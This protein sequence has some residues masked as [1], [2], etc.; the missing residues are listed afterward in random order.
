MR[1]V[2]T[3]L[4]LICSIAVHAQ[5]TVTGVVKDGST[6]SP[7]PFASII[8]QDGIIIVGDL[9]GKFT[10]E[11]QTLQQELTISYT[12]YEDKTIKLQAGK[13]FYTVKLKAKPQELNEVII[14]QTDAGAQIIRHAINRKSVND[15]QQKLNSFRY[16]TY[17]RLII[18]A[19]PDSLS[20]KIDSVFVSEKAGRVLEKI[21]STGFKF[22]K[23]IEK[24][25]LYQTE[26]VS[27]YNYTKN[28]GLKE[29]ILA[30]RMAGFKEPIY[31]FIGLQLQSYSVYNDVDLLETKYIG[32]LDDN[33]FSEYKYRVLDTVA[34]DNRETYMI[35]FTPKRA[36]KKKRLDGILYIDRATFG[37]AKAVFRVKN[38]LDINSTHYFKFEKDLNL[39]FPD[40]KTLKIVKGNNKQDINILGETIKFDA[41]DEASIPR[42]KEASDFVYVYSESVNSEKEFNIPLVIKNPAIAIEIKEEAI[43]RPEEYWKQYRTTTLD[44]RGLNTYPA[45]DS[46]VAEEKIE[47]LVKLG[48]RVITGYLP[49]GF[50]DLDLR[51]IVKYNNYEGFRLGLGGIT[52]KKFSETFRIGGYGVYGTKDGEFKYNLG[53]AVRIGKFSDSWIGGSY[54]E[55]VQEIGST[56]FATDKRVFKIYDPR[57][58]NVSTFYKYWRWQA[59]LET[60][61]IPKTESRWS[62]N[63]TAVDPRFDYVFNVND[64][65]YSSYNLST[66]EGT[67]QWNPFSD[68]MQTPEGRTEVEKRFP[69]FTFQ[70]TQAIK[71][72]LDGDFNF[73]KFDFRAEYEKKYINGQK[74][75]IVVQTGLALGEIPITHLYSTSPNNLDKD[76][77]IARITFAGKNSFETMYFNEFFSSQYGMFQ[78]KHALRRQNLFWKIKL[79]PVLVTR[80]V[81]GN[82]EHQERQ[83]GQPYKTLE[84]GY[85]E[86]G[87]E[88]N[89]IF[90]GLGL[91]FFYRYGP[92]H[93][94]DFDR[95][96]SIKLSFVLKL[97]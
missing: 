16:K 44:E 8:A 46:L 43:S 2:Y 23:L 38:V 53:A 76:G 90:Q 52:N 80:T 4:L 19:N 58:I 82:M 77:V 27:E 41:I 45:L 26:K 85:Y 91:T 74:T 42:E 36:K 66:F 56:N 5:Y 47:K 22:K 72:A 25:H 79:T 18:T 96:I 28:E 48:K 59:Y 97:F 1:V 68:F 31:E 92:Y 54:T 7:L 39:W 84:K 88:L 14:T 93:L 34:I 6:N 10:L 33:A 73:S 64:Q 17:N 89:E 9:D 95:N 15:P 51:Q 81:W 30:T 94:P 32:P 83:V 63:H 60:K 40:K 21:D 86:S 71:G 75:S 35:Y 69:K 11:T 67:V 3:L 70:Y 20:G 78:F 87:L 57:P 65:L 55:D 12:G 29:N 13:N 61:I 50:F 37:V 49:I 24:Q 62:F